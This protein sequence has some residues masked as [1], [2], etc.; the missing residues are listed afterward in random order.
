MSFGSDLNSML[1][2]TDGSASAKDAVEFA[3][4]LAAAH[5]AAL[6]V[7]H[8]VRTLDI[9]VDDLD[10]APTPHPREGGPGTTR[11]GRWGSGRFGAVRAPGCR[12]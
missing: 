5:D 12:P 11:C 8:V 4:T 6:L 3:T 2:A 1:V 10:A 7:V 9:V